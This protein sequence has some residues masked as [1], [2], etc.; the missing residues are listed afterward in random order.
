MRTSDF[1]YELPPELIAQHPATTRDGSRLLRVNRSSC[2]FEHRRFCEIPDLLPEK[3][4]IV[5]NDSKVIPARLRAID[6]STAREFEVMLIERMGLNE[7]WA[8]VRPGRHAPTGKTLELLSQKGTPSGIAAE[9]VEVN[10]E[11]HRKFRFH[12]VRDLQDLLPELGEMPLPPYIKRARGNFSSEDWER[13]QTTYAKNPGSVAAPTAGLHFTSELLTR[14]EHSGRK[15]IR[16]TLHVGAGTFA[17]VKHDR[18]EEHRMHHEQYEVSESAAAELSEAAALGRP[19]IAVGTTAARVLES[20]P[21]QEDG[22]FITHRGSTNLF[23]HPPRTFNVISGLIT[24]F[25][26]PQSTLLMLVSAF[27]APG[28][29]SGRELILK[30]YAEA[31]RERY[32]FFSYGDAMLIL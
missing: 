23:I 24:N 26:L 17:P 3:C 7:W 29:T 9:V 31:I 14:L 19:I 1:D 12:H 11:G 13:Y 8:M 5:I 18:L 22:S 20:T 16:T 15:I 6:T 10:P 25:H 30:A 4:L 27:A 21:R 32:R 2:T 28:Q